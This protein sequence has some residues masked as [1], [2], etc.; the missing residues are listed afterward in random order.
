MEAQTLKLLLVWILSFSQIFHYDHPTADILHEDFSDR[1]EWRGT[2]DKDIQTGAIYIQNVTFN[3][4][5]TYLCTFQRTLFLALSNE[6]VTV[7]KEVE[8]SV[9]VVGEEGGASINSR[10][11]TLQWCSCHRR[12]IYVCDSSQG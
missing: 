6:H 9:V 2:L 3:D 4:T 8:L 1:L 12:H 11:E 5:G 7:E 10:T